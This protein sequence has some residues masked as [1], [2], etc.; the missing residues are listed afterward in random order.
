VTKRLFGL[1]LITTA[2]TLGHHIDHVIRGNHVGW[3]FASTVTP[4]TLSLAVYPAV[5]A[6][7]YLSLRGRVG[8][9]Y[10][11]IVWGT[12]TLLAASVH[13]P[14]SENSETAGDIIHPYASPLAGW[15]AFLWLL[16]LVVTA[17]VTFVETMRLWVRQRGQPGVTHG[18]PSAQRATTK[19]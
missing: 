18:R 1:V 17:M 12:M 3:P 9:G 8:P 7:L 11:A 13:L 2:L 14:L 15:V 6:G 16:A 5:I 10:W 4:F 19:T